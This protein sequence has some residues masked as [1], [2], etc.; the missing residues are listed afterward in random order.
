MVHLCLRSCVI[1]ACK[2]KGKSPINFTLLLV[3]M[4]SLSVQQWWDTA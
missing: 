3:A 1:I 4:T 2:I